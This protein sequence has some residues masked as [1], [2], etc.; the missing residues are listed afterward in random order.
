VQRALPHDKF[1][2][3]FADT[4]MELD[5]TYRSI[6]LAQERWSDINWHTARSHLSAPESWN[7]I[8]AP[9]Q[10]LRWCCAVHKT[11]PQVLL[12]K[13]LVKKDRFKTLVYVGVRAEESEARSQYEDIS[14]SKKHVMQTGCYPILEWNTSELFV[15]ILSNNL[16]LNNAYKKGL[17]RAGCIFCPM[18]SNWSFMV[19]G[20]TRKDK[21]N[22]YVNVIEQQLNQKFSTQD[23]KKKYFQDVQWKY[24]FNGRDIRNGNNKYI[25]TADDG[26]T[27]IFLMQPSSQWETWISTIAMLHRETEQVYS[28]EYKSIHLRLYCEK[29]DTSVKI[30]FETL[31]KTQVSI[32]LMHL[33]RNAFYKAAYCIG[34]KACEVECPTGAIRFIDGKITIKG[35][36]HCENCLERTKGCIV[37]ESH[38]IPI[39]GTNMTKKSIAA[40]QTRGL[41]QDWLDLYFELGADFWGNDRLGK[42]MFLSF[43]TWIKEAGLINGLSKTL[44]GEKL[45]VLGVN[46]ILVWSTIFNNLAYESTLINWYV[47]ALDAFQPYDNLTL[48]LLLGEQYSIS[49]KDSGIASLKETLKVSP[50][51]KVLG[52]GECEL[53]GNT[54]ISITKTTWHNPEPLAILY[55]LF[56]FAEASDRYYSFTLTDLLADSPERS[57]ISPA[58]LFN[59]SRETLQQILFQLSYDYSGFVKVVFNKDLDNIY[60]N[61][62]KTALDVAGLF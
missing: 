33:I 56:K 6:E 28:L 58:K 25:E 38:T 42:N 4:T 2:V 19:N 23:M 39:G 35:C 46:N 47:K 55:S 10:K 52:V 31:E 40:Y 5:D 51:G 44:L 24:R 16:L 34:C 14:E 45:S 11:V 22:E 13:N 18:S 60:L 61:S 7:M 41:R 48:K 1:I 21:T 54:V 12:I 50:I 26:K 53:K 20:H 57:G 37:A 36:V 43:K 3:V 15:Y 29:F 62:E 8:G 27:T 30:T 17:T 32:R 49:V 59:I 9:A